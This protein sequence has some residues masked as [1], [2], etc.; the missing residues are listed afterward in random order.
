MRTRTGGGS[1]CSV[2]TAPTVTDGNTTGAFELFRNTQA[3]AVTIATAIDTSTWQHNVTEWNYL[4]DAPA[5]VLEGN[6]S[7]QIWAICQAATGYISIY[8][9]ELGENDI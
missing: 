6:A 2:Y 8:W 5:P 4:K 1:N 3:K 9:L 7:L